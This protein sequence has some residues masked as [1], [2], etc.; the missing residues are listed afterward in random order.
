MA[1]SYQQAIE[2]YR[3]G[4]LSTGLAARMAGVPRTTFFYLLSQHGLSPFGEEPDEIEE[5]LKHACAA[6]YR[7]SP[8]PGNLTSPFC[9]PPSTQGDPT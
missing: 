8:V 4:Q 2:L 5:D 1:P 3:S 6:S 9:P 7:Q